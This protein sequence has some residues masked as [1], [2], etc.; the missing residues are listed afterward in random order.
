MFSGTQCLP[1][2]ADGT[3]FSKILTR[4]S[5][6]RDTYIAAYTNTGK[7]L[8]IAQGASS[9][10]SAMGRIDAD[11]S[12]VYFTGSFTGGPMRI[13]GTL[14]QKSTTDLTQLGTQSGFVAKLSL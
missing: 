13:Y 1:Y 2:N 5:T 14:G 3:P 4:R 10:N 9:I 7:V 12:G 6:T 11:S 8:W